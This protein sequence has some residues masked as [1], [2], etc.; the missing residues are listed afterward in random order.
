MANLVVDIGNS[1]VKVAVVECDKVLQ[2]QTVNDFAQVDVAALKERYA[3]LQRAVVASTAH[4]TLSVAQSLRDNGLEVL[5][6]TSLTPTPI[7]N[8]YGTPETL[9]VDR[10][11]AAV[12]A[13]EVMGCK[14]CL[15]V[16]FGTAI[17]IDVVENGAFRGGNISPGVRTRFRALHDYTNRLPECQPTDEEREFGCTTS[18]AIEQGVMQGITNEIEGYISRFRAKNVKISLIF[19]GGD[20]NFFVKRIKNAIFAEY[21][22]VICGLNRILEYNASTEQANN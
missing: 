10:L 4:P 7:G 22:L 8:E 19:T 16:D 9:G 13:V 18:Q 5:E 1:L 15:I 20:A 17:T 12:A 2:M 21:E 3:T 14:D 6:M 11:A